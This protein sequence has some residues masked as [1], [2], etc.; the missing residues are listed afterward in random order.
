[1]RLILTVL[2]T[3]LFISCRTKSPN[4][5]FIVEDFDRLHVETQKGIDD[6]EVIDVAEKDD[7]PEDVAQPKEVETKP[8]EKK[9]PEGPYRWKIG[10]SMKI[11]LLGEPKM[12]ETVK[13][14]EDGTITYHFPVGTI[15]AEGKTIDEIRTVI[16]EKLK[17]IYKNPMVSV[18]PDELFKEEPEK[19]E[20]KSNSALT[21]ANLV[22][23][24]KEK[25]VS[26]VGAV[27][28]SGRYPIR[29]G[30]RILDVL[31]MSGGVQTTEEFSGQSNSSV[32]NTSGAVANLERA[33]IAR[34]GKILKVDFRK[35]LEED[36][37]KHN[38][39]VHDGDYIY[40]PESGSQR[41]Y[42]MGF[43]KF[44]RAIPIVSNMTLA[45]AIVLSG[46]FQ[47]T[48]TKKKIHILRGSM[49]NPQHIVC[50][51]EDF[52]GGKNAH[53]IR[54]KPEDIIYIPERGKS[55]GARTAQQIIQML[56]VIITGDEAKKRLEKNF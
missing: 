44:P 30:D 23:S 53:N 32:L 24:K 20:D 18:L 40:I 36:N 28:K 39:Q 55:F 3:A 11:F 17:K 34:K 54:L 50:N 27:S 19:E 29:K 1:M 6:S 48:G 31:A 26:I 42:V 9:R 22:V 45:K 35:L 16:T 41:V 12:N 14:I 49:R 4:E 10:D 38:I 52:L 21:Q 46:G 7:E 51:L 13:V 5:N 8:K 43:V 37:L 15:K 47:D 2:L 56:G 33:Y 25:L